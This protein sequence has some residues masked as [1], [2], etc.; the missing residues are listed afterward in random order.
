MPAKKKVTEVRDAK[1]LSDLLKMKSSRYMVAITIFDEDEKQL[2]SSAFTKDFPIGDMNQS[3]QDMAK[4]V[5]NVHDSEQRMI[6]QPK[7]VQS[8]HTANL[9][10]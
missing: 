8:E 2:H 5:K 7:D 10:K 4:C 9:I 3:I 1:Q 6:K